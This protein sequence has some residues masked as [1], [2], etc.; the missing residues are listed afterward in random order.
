MRNQEIRKIVFASLFAATASILKIYSLQITTTWRISLFPIALILAGY[1]LGPLYGLAVGFVT[2]TVYMFISPF[3]HIWSIYTLS[4]MI[5]GL[6][7]YILSVIKPNI[8]LFI[9]VITLTS[10]LET[11]INSV[12]MLVESG[13]SWIT[14]YAGLGKRLITL[15]LRLPVLV[16]ITKLII[17]R[18]KIMEITF[19]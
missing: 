11:T 8:L 3:A 2:D 19:T 7:G 9:L 16:I 4:T 18:L 1:F 14:V 13:I 15:V 12:A 5:W 10:L 17:K 6:S